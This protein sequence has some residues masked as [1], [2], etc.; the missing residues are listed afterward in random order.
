M[1]NSYRNTHWCGINVFIYFT[2]NLYLYL[3]SVVEIKL[4]LILNLMGLSGQRHAL[5]TQCTDWIGGW[6]SQLSHLSQ[7]IEV[8]VLWAGCLWFNSW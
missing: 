7:V 6:A 4:H 5:A 8:T 3:H 1:L 2:V